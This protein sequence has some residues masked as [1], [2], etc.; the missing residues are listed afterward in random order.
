MESHARQA[1]SIEIQ[2][3]EHDL[4][5]M[6]SRAETMVAQ[7][8]ECLN[9]LDTPLAH[10]VMALDDDL[11]QMDLDIE[12]HC[13]RLLALQQPMASDLRV[14]GTVM[15]MITDVERIGDLSVDIAKISLKIEKEFGDTRFVDIPHMAVLARSMLR[16]SL[17]AFVRRDLDM[18]AEVA[19]KDD[20]VD[21]V[22]RDLREQIF[23][24]MR[25]HP[26]SVVAASWLLLA[27]HHIERIADHAVN[28]AERV[29]FMVTGKLEQLGGLEPTS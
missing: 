9:K 27:I 26:E 22:Y 14:I 18:V 13:L 5:A 2:G 11:D 25:H 12:A 4:L 17:E 16:E 29:A 21:A 7:A 8:V 28:I 24:H 6:G 20:E 15:K 19:R 10:S 23:E 3:L 1:F